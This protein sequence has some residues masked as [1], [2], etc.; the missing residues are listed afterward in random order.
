MTAKYRFTTFFIGSNFVSENKSKKHKDENSNHHK[1]IKSY[2]NSNV[3]YRIHSNCRSDCNDKNDFTINNTKNNLKI[4]KM[5]T[6]NMKIEIDKMKEVT[7]T[8][9]KWI[10]AFL[11]IAWKERECICS[12]N[13]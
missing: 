9:I 2:S 7:T 11:L 12:G 10:I 13:N 6:L 5:K 3:L 1:S 4:I 8:I